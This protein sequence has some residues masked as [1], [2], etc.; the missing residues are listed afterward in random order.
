MKTLSLRIVRYLPL[1]PLLFA[2][3]AFGEED[4]GIISG[5]GFVT[6]LNRMERTITINGEKFHLSP[7]AKLH[8]FAKKD[9]N[10]AYPRKGDTVLFRL[11]STGSSRTIV[12]IWSQQ[13]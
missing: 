2:A 13:E 3:S 6:S 12:E 8:G 10:M 7:K 5:E 11:E 4:I 9:K 1:L